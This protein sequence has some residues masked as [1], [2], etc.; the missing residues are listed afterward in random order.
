MDNKLLVII[1]VQND[2]INKNTKKILEK[3]K[4]LINSKQYENMVFTKFINNRDSR[5]YNDL[6]YK[7]C[8]TEKGMELAIEHKE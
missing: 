4:E 2:F 7:G 5:F 3:I 8:L 6:Q 1:D